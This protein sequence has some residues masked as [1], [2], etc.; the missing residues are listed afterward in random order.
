V[1]TVRTQ[2][3]ERLRNARLSAASPSGSGRPMSRQ[4]LADL[5]NALMVDDHAADATMN[6]NYIG[7]LERGKHRWPSRPRR[8]ALCRVLGVSREADLGFFINREYR[9]AS[10]APQRA[11][12]PEEMPLTLS[13][14]EDGSRRELLKAVAAVATSCGLLGFTKSPVYRRIGMSDI[15]RI[16]AVTSLYRSVDYERGGGSLRDEL[17]RFAEATSAL[18]ARA[19]AGCWQPQLAAA[20]AAARQLAGWTAFDAGRHSDAG[21]HWLSAE[22]AALAAGDLRLVARIR[23]CQARQF[24]HLQHNQDALDTLRLAREQLTGR[25]T[26][27]LLAMLHGAEAASLAALGDFTAATTALRHAD[28]HFGRIAADWEPDW[29][30][31]YDHGELLA[32]YGRV[33]RDLARAD[34]RHADAAVD[35]THQAINAL[36]PQNVRSTV[37]NEVGL[38][39][40]LALAGEFDRVVEMGATVIAHGRQL[41]SRR[42]QDRIRNLTRD[43]PADARH[44]DLSD[45]RHHL[46]Q[47]RV[48]AA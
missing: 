22:R 13:P 47:I 33:H 2:P 44:S 8:E 48:T 35:W 7:K 18:L 16:D 42:I 30:R 4:E 14:V 5:A 23:Y 24:Q 46:S 26:P 15:A 32:Q 45:F 36:G 1:T 17:G 9:A 21:R 38:C 12:A 29:M 25:A 28:D 10:G 27:A 41:T 20:V 34:S 6:A 43:I 40:A 3:N 37:L 19:D 31:F 11:L 39:S